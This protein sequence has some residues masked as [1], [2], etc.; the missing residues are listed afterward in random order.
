MDGGK[1]ALATTGEPM[2]SQKHIEYIV[3]AHQNHARKQ[4]KAFRKHDGK[5]PY[6]I[7]P[8]WCATTILTE[9][10]LDEKT[11]NEGAIALLYHDVL[12]DT[13]QQ[14]PQDLEERIKYLVREMTFSSSEE[15][16]QQVWQKPKEIRLYKL[17]DK[18][19]NL[20]DGSWMPEEKRKKYQ[21]YAKRLSE[22]VATNYGELN[23]TKIVNSIRSQK[24]QK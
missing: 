7:H 17:Y 3:N 19:N 12:E 9:T 18:V 5:T 1:N 2:I 14:L 23:I 11:K 20:L 16:M 13:T 24:Y 4:S 10:N 6:W 21:S 8:L 15:E 22:D